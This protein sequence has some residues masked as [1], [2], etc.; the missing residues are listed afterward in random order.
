[1]AARFVASIR[2]LMGVLPKWSLGRACCP[3]RASNTIEARKFTLFSRADGALGTARPTIFG[4]TTWATRPYV[5]SYN[6]RQNQL[7][8]TP[9]TAQ[10]VP[11]RMT[12][13]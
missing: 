7:P 13:L 3:E 10:S 4:G 5:I 6:G 8:N 11:L 2:L 12:A 9:L 1:M